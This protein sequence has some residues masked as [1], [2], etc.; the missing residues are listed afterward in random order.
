M[1]GPLP[2]LMLVAGWIEMAGGFLIAIGFFAGIAAFVASGEMAAAYFMAHAK[3]TGVEWI[4]FINKGEAAV[5]YC[6]IFLYIAAHGAG[7]WSVDNAM[8]KRTPVV[9]S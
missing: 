4:P 9:T 2:P 3:W 1:K 7:I 5:L 6:F 8:R